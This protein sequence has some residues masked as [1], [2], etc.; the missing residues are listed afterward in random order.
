MAGGDTENRLFGFSF[1]EQMLENGSLGIF[2]TSKCRRN[3][4]IQ[5]IHRV[6]SMI[7][8]LIPKVKQ[9]RSLQ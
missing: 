2:S 7:M 1:G 4:K 8:L 6:N 5:Q 9:I 3:K